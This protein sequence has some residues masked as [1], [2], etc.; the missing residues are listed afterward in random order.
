MNW[1][2]QQPFIENVQ[3]QPDDIDELGHA[4]NAVYVGWLERCAWQHSKSLGLGLEEYQQLNRAMV[5][6]RHEI[7]YLAAAY[8]GEKLQMATWVVSWVGKLRMTRR[9]QLV[10]PSD[11]LTLLRAITTFACVEMSSGRPRRM[12]PEFIEGYGQAIVE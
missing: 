11:G 5:V 9:F 12:P 1:D 6:V 4:N 10:R 3:V 2:L 8:A 7:D